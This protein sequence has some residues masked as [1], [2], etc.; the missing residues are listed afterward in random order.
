MKIFRSACG[1]IACVLLVVACGGTNT[2][3]AAPNQSTT[4][5]T[6]VENPP[7]RIASL[8]ATTFQA[9]LNST[10]AGQQLLQVTGSPVCG[11]DFYYMKFNTLG[12][13]NETTV[14]SGALMVP[15]G[16]AGT[17]SGPRP[18]VL[19]AHGTQTLQTAN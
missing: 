13:A 19:Y 11:V 2:E 18:I 3:T 9:Q 5:G 6:L 14:S 4:H 17:C 7:V 16:P 1:A 12:A 10:S 15:T 8:D